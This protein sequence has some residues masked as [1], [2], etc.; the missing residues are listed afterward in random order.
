MNERR[1]SAPNA[2]GGSAATRMRRAT[3]AVPRL[4]TVC[5]ALM[6]SWLAGC[7][8]LPHLPDDAQFKRPD[9]YQSAASFSAPVSEWPA[10]GWWHRYGDSQLDQLIDQALAGSPTLAMARARLEAAQAMSQ[11]A[12]ASRLPQ[13]SAN[14]AAVEGKQSYNFLA[15]RAALPQGWNDYRR[16][17]MSGPPRL[18]WIRPA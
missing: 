9:A 6:M 14:A 2:L 3:S 4:R 10:N 11:I 18:R 7:A 17:P 16:S 15:P 1:A 13:V 5:A 8:A 12:G